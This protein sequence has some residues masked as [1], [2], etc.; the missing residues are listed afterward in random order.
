MPNGLQHFGVE[1]IAL[2][3]K[4]ALQLGSQGG[5]LVVAVQPES[6]AARGGLRAGD[7]IETID[8]RAIGRGVWSVRNPVAREKKHVFSLVR[9]R[10]KKQIVVEAVE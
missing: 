9:E 4:M 7:V 8:G 2:T 10:E 6:M 3:K 1:T 5:L